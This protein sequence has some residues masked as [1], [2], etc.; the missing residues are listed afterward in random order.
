MLTALETN[1][2]V[3][4]VS[5]FDLR[6][7]IAFDTLYFTLPGLPQVF[8]AE[9]NLI[10]DHP[11]EGFAWSAQL[12]N[13][14]GS[15]SLIWHNGTVSG[16]I[17]ADTNLYELLP[18]EG[19]YQFLVE[20]QYNTGNPLPNSSAP[21]EPIGNMLPGGSDPDPD[22]SF[23]LD[24]NPYNTCEATIYVLIIVTQEAKNYILS[25]S[26]YNSIDAFIAA[27]RGTVNQAFANSDI[28]AKQIFVKWIER[29]IELDYPDCP[30]PSPG[31]GD[32]YV[33]AREMWLCL[34]PDREA[35]KADLVI[36][37]TSNRYPESGGT[38]QIGPNTDMPVSIVEAE[39]FLA[40]SFSF[41]HEIGH[42]LGAR[43]NW[44]INYFGDDGYTTCAHA[45]RWVQNPPVVVS[46]GIYNVTLYETIL[47]YQKYDLSGV[48]FP[49]VSN[50]GVPYQAYINGSVRL[51]NYS[52]PA[53]SVLSYPTG[54]NWADNSKLIRNT[55]CVVA[56]FFENHFLGISVNQTSCN[57][58]PMVLTA[59]ISVPDPGLP[60][61]GPYTIKWY[62]NGILKGTG[63]TLTI[64]QHYECPVYWIKCE[65]TSAD[66]VVV[67]KMH[68][69]DLRSFS[70]VQC[71]PTT[72]PGGGSGKSGER[73]EAPTSAVNVTL[74]VFPNP[75]V[76]SQLIFQSTLFSAPEAV[77]TIYDEQGE[78][79][80]C[81]KVVFDASGKGVINVSS[82]SPGFHMLSIIDK[83]G[84][85]ESA[86]FLIIKP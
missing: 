3:R 34:Q 43:H 66:G 74:R 59:N 55:A 70:C 76:G 33:D 75:V 13:T 19:T 84:H 4:V 47:G 45:Y 2:S 15:M 50:T 48:L 80:Y 86:K 63:L 78:Q 60:G 17:Q 68:K 77:G 37:L 69:V 23:P 46:G 73:S 85:Q 64:P 30:I 72:L 22:C 57:I 12:L 81:D 51:L 29:N 26:G 54:R 56:D 42:L 44:P 36:M 32:I 39:D 49:F 71:P 31:E 62:H 25:H 9:A 11:L 16:Y 61:V 28:P 21:P 18:A 40:P 5:T 79:V 10:E 1:K 20:R 65:L 82:L 14:P 27:G 6:D 7:S 8:M 53:V 67:T 38:P 83:T 24:M 35:N 52:N 58:L 41:A